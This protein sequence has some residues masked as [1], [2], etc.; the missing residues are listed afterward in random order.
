MRTLL[1]A[2]HSSSM[3]FDLSATSVMNLSPS[4]LTIPRC[5]VGSLIDSWN[6]LIVYQSYIMHAGVARTL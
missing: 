5:S 3:K 6:V 4:C 1:I 2:F